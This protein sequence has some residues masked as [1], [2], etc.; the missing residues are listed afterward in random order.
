MVAGAFFEVTGAF[1]ELLVI[2]KAIGENDGRLTAD[3]SASLDLWLEMREEWFKLHDDE[4]LKRAQ[5]AV[6]NTTLEGDALEKGPNVAIA[7][8]AEFAFIWNTA[9]PEHRETIVAVLMARQDEAMQCF[10][11]DHDG[12]K[13]QLESSS[14]RIAELT[15]K[16]TVTDDQLGI[17]A[18]KF[19]EICHDILM[20]H[21]TEKVRLVEGLR[22]AM[23]AAGYELP[24][25]ADSWTVEYMHPGCGWCE[26]VAEQGIRECEESG[27]DFA[28]MGGYDTSGTS[29]HAAEVKRVL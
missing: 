18:Q 17:M 20:M 26:D 27:A 2:E 23:L 6:E 14:R 15:A 29:Y 5:G 19:Y 28:S 13:E 8:A 4:V 16:S 22:G 10:M 3:S 12:L 1:S 9:T 7:S 11:E 21:M 24:K 25:K